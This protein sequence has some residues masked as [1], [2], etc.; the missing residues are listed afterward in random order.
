MEA[1]DQ[2]P[3]VE[4]TFNDGSVEEMRL[5]IDMYAENSNLYVALESLDGT[6]VVPLTVNT[7]IT[8]GYPYATADV[9]GAGE[10]VVAWLEERGLARFTGQKVHGQW[11]SWPIMAFN[12]EKLRE[13]DPE[14]FSAYQQAHGFLPEKDLDDLAKEAKD[15]AAEKNAQR[16]QTSKGRDPDLGR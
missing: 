7:S 1:N 3:V 2:R 12:P 4:W 9:G 5:S 10:K 14:V 8:M 15:R 16:P 11:L 6:E 13:I